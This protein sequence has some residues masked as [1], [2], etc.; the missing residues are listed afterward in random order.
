MGEELD[1]YGPFEVD[2]STGQP[3]HGDPVAA[4]PADY[5]AVASEL[6]PIN[7]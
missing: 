4:R 2:P 5:N 6:P 7:A 3:I 1:L